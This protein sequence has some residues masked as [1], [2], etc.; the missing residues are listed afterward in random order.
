MRKIFERIYISE[1]GPLIFKHLSSLP[2]RPNSKK[3]DLGI[4]KNACLI[5]W[6]YLKNLEKE[7]KKRNENCELVNF[8]IP[9]NFLVYT[10]PKNPH[11]LLDYN[12]RIEAYNNKKL[13][14]NVI[15]NSIK[16]GLKTIDLSEYLDENDYLYHDGHF[17]SN[18][19]SKVSN[20]IIKYLNNF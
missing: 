17:N 8:L 7:C 11:T 13:I 2:N 1:F 3:F 19:H 18:G 15:D 10:N 16:L 12:E 5:N 20:I 6:G 4:D 9:Q 14:K